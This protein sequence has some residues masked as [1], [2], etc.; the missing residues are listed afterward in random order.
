MVIQFCGFTSMLL[1]GWRAR[2]RA[3]HG[4]WSY[5]CPI[6]RLRLVLV[7][8]PNGPRERATLQRLVLLEA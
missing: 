6:A 2:V 3:S 7:C 4:A 1:D 8:L 5:H